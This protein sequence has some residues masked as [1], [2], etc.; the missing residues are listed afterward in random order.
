MQLFRRPLSLTLSTRHIFFSSS[1]FPPLSASSVMH[2]PQ[3]TPTLG[4]YLS[5]LHPSRV[6]SLPSI[7]RVLPFSFVCPIS[8]LYW[9]SCPAISYPRSVF[10]VRSTFHRRSQSSHSHCCPWSP[11]SRTFPWID[12]HPRLSFSLFAA[13]SRSG[14]RVPKQ[15]GCPNRWT[16]M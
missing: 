8:V 11:P 1:I 13:I 10:F 5:L 7:S 14:I 9:L 15:T 16:P 12:R 2:F 4:P 6:R 3:H